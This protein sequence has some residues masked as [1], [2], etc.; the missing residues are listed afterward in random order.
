[1]RH[2]A[3]LSDLADI[4][5]TEPEMT[6]RL[7][8]PYSV[9][10]RMS[11]TSRCRG[12]QWRGLP[13]V[14]RPS[15]SVSASRSK[16]SAR[17]QLGKVSHL[18]M[19]TSRQPPNT[20]HQARISPFLPQVFRHHRSPLPPP[21][22]SSKIGSAPSSWKPWGRCS[23]GFHSSPLLVDDDNVGMIIV[24]ERGSLIRNC[25]HLVH[26]LVFPK[27]RNGS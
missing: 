19:V 26:T 20:I 11:L 12:V 7:P 23:I 22:L 27:H 1:M 3:R 14:A 8:L 24:N 21:S 9:H 10:T 6:Q 18:R 4:L 13:E 16:P 5:G 17:P 2:H 15:G 25:D